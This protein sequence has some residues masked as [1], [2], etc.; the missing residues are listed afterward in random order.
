M[1]T[2]LL[3]AILGSLSA[4]RVRYEARSSARQL[5]ANLRVVHNGVE[6]VGPNASPALPSDR[7]WLAFSTQASLTELDAKVG[8]IFVALEEHSE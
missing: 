7:A 3:G 8:G 6:I 1:L 2:R 5:L 4:C